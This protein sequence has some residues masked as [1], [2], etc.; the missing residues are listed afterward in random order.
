MPVLVP[1]P[2]NAD[3]ISHPAMGVDVLADRRCVPRF[4]SAANGVL[5]RA[6]WG[7]RLCIAQGVLNC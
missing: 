2:G 6:T 1:M 5:R 7:R 4:W 3:D